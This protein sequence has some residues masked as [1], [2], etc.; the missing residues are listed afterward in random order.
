M[1]P[2]RWRGRRGRRKGFR[3]IQAGQQR[4]RAAGKPDRAHRPGSRLRG[5]SSLLSNP[6]F[7]GQDGHPC[8]LLFPASRFPSTAV[9]PA[10]PTTSAGRSRTPQPKANVILTKPS[11]LIET[12]IEW[13]GDGLLPGESISRYRGTAG[14]A[15]SS[16]PSEVVASS[17]PA[18]QEEV[19]EAEVI[20]AAAY[21]PPVV[22]EAAVYEEEVVEAPE[23]GAPVAEA[24][25]EPEPEVQTVS[26]QRRGRACGAG[27]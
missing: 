24:A 14:E 4:G 20:P 13:N 2:G 8:R 19:H 23:Q 26:G 25:S 7:G 18:L 11:T 17:A 5:R 27:G 16:F 21:E 12:P 15:P 1:E 22:H 9:K 3:P 6:R 10:T